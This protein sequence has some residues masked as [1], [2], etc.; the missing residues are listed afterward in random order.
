MNVQALSVTSV[1]RLPHK[2]VLKR[3][4]AGCLLLLLFSISAFADTVMTIWPSNAVPVRVD[5]GPDSAVELGVKFKSDVA[6]TIVGIRF[7]KGTANTGI[8]VGNLWSSAGARL[9]TATFSNETASGWQQVFFTTPVTI[10]S[11]TVYVA[12][13]YANN[14]HYSADTDYFSGKGVDNPPLHAL[15]NST[16]SGNGVYAYGT[17]SAFPNQ[18]WNAANYWV[19]V[20]FQAEQ[21]TLK[22][23]AVMPTNPTIWIG[24][25]LQFTATGTYSNGSTNNVSSQV[26]WTSSNTGVAT[27]NTNGL[28]TGVSTGTTTISVALAGVSNSTT[29]TVQA[30]PMLTSITVTP[31]NHNLERGR[32]LQ[33]TATGAYSNG[34]TNNVSS[35]VTWTSSNTGVATINTSGLATGV[36]TGTTT[37]SATL[38]NV[39]G[40]TMLTVQP[41][42]LSI[43]TTS[44]PPGVVNTAYSTTLAASGGTLPYTWSVVGGSLP[45]GLTLNTGSGTISGTPTV[46][47]TSNFTIQLRDAN[48]QTTNKVLSLTITST[49]IPAI[50][51]IWPSNAV[52]GN[53]DEGA[54]N[55]V[56]LGVKFKSDVAGTIVGIRFYKG[57]ANTGTHVGNLWSS[58]GAQLA[59]ATFSSETASGWQQ[60]FFTTPVTIASNTVYVASYHANNGHYSA[61]GNY[62][63]GKG[64]DNPPLHALT[65][66]TSSGNGVYVYGTSS[67]FP[68][69]TWNAANYWVDVLFQAEQLTLKSITVMPANPN[70]ERGRTLQ[71]TA[72]GAYS[73]GSTNNVSSQV[74]WTSSNT[75][76]ATINTSGLATGVSTGM[77][78][79]SAAL[80]S[81][82]NST[83]LTVQVPRTLTS[84]S[85]T[86]MNPP[87]WVGASLQFIATGTYSDGNTNNVSSQVT[88]TSSNTGVATI[89]TSGLATGVATGTTT[90]SA[91]LTNVVGSTML[92]V[93]PAPLSITTTSFSTGFV[94]TAYSTTLAASGGTLPYIWSVV[95]GSLPSGLTLNTGSGTISGTPTVVGTSN[96]T[97]QL[98]DA[99]SQTTNKVLSLTITSTSIPAI[100]TIWPSNAVP[101]NVDE[102]ADNPVELGVKFKSDV[103]GTIVGIRFYKA[104]ANTGTH[105]GNLWSSA[106]AQLATATFSSETA[107][108]WQQ[109]FFTTPVTIASNTVY[110]ASYHANNGHYSADGNYF[111]EKGVDNP[112][113]H[114]LTNSTSSGNGVYAYGTSSAFPNQTW[115]AANYWVDVLFQAGLRTLTSITVTP[116]SPS[117]WRGASLQFMATGTYSDGSTNNVSS[118]VTWTSSNMGVAT[119]N[120]NGLVTG[121][122][123]GAT[124]ISATLAGVSNST[125]LTVLPPPMLTSIT[126]TPANPNLERGRTLQFTAKGTYSDGSTQTLNQ[127]TWISSN[128]GVATINTNGLATGVSTGTT[129]ISATWTNVVGSTM[130]TV[131]SASLSITTISLPN[132]VVN[133]SY[134]ATLTAIGGTLPYTWSIASGSLPSGLTLNAANGVITGTPTNTGTVSFTA[135]VRDASN[136]AQTASNVLSLTIMPS[137][138]MVTIWPSNAMPARVDDGPSSPVELGVKFRSDVNGAIAGIR[139]YKAAAN[140]GTHVGNLWSITGTQLATATFANESTSGWQQVLFAAPV[141]ITSNTVYVA[142][143]H[144]NNGHYSEDDNYFQGK[145][146][147]N[148][149]LHALTNGVSGGNGVYVYGANSAFPNQTWLAANYWVD[150]LFQA[151]PITLRSIAVTPTN[152]TISTG[153]SQQFT[154]MGTFSDGSMQNLTSQA[155]WTSSNT[156]VA[157]IN[158]DGLAIGISADATT[159]SASLA[160]VV[161]STLLTVKS[162]SLSIT[163]IS[164]TN[165]VVNMAYTATLSASGGTSPY[166][167][168]IAGG[169]LPSGLTLNPAGGTITGTPT[170]TGTN[171]FTVQVRDTGNPAQTT[172]NLF[173]II[174][175]PALATIWPSTVVPSVVD[176][177]SDSAVELGV[178]FRSAVDGAITGIRFYKATA[179]TGTH[180]GN[181]WSITGTQLATATFSNETAAGW[182]QVLFATPVTIT[183]NTV[184]VASYH[185]NN[186]HYSADGNYF[187][188]K[189]VDNPPLY[190]LTNGVSGGNGVYA[191]GANSAFPNQT[192]NAANYWVDVLFRAGPPPN[193]TSIA[194]T[195]ANSMILMGDLKQ[196]TATGIYSDGSVQDV[197]SQATW[198]SSKPGVARIIT[199]GVVIGVSTGTTTISATLT[200]VVGSTTLTVQSAPLSI[201]TT[202][203]TNGMVNRPYAATLTANGGTFLP[204]T[205]SIAEGSLPVGLTLN[206]TNGTIT[207]TPTTTGTVYFTAHVSDAGNPIQTA[208][209]SLG[210]TIVPLPALVTIWPSTAVPGQM[211]SGPESP[212]EL[213]VKFRSDATGSIVGIRFYKSTANLGTHMGNLWTSNGILLATTTFTNETGWGWQQTYFATPVAIAS[214]TVYVASY[215]ANNG[216]YSADRDYF[217]GKGADNPPLH[218]LANGVSGGNGVYAYGASSTFPNQS[219][220]AANYWVDVIFRAGPLPT[221]TSIV[222]T[223]TN[224]SIIPGVSTQFMATGTFSDGSTQSLN[225]VTWTSLN[226][227]VATINASGLA[228]GISP[229]AT[230]ISAALTNVVGSTTLT[231][232]SAPLSIKTISLP[233]G[234]VNAAYSAKLTANGGTLPYTWSIT[235]GTLPSG[236]TLNTAAGTITGMPTTAGAVSFTAHVQDASNPLQTVTKS[237]SIK[238]TPVS[239]IL[240]VTNMAN[241]FSQYYA[242]ILLT[243][244]LNEFDLKD[245]SFVSNET[246]LAPYD[247]VILGQVA[248]QPSQV[249]IVSNWVN[250]GGNLIAMRPDKKLAGL[251]GLVD[252]GATMANRYLLVNTSTGPGAGIV[253]ETIQFHGT[254]DCYTVAS[255]THIVSLATL[256]SNVQTAT[257]HPAVTLRSVGSNGGQAAAFT[258]DL[259]RS[260]VY[261]RQGNPAWAGQARDGLLPVRS[262]DL[263]YGAATNDMQPDWIDLTNNKV[264][265]PQADEQQRLLANLILTMNSD[266]NLLP[267]FW[268][269]PHGYEAVVVMTEDDHG[270][271]VASR[272]DQ[273]NAFSPTNG[274]MADWETIRSTAYMFTNATLI[275]AQASNYNAVGFEIGLHLNTQCANYTRESLHVYFAEQLAQFS[276]IYPSV[277]LPKTLRAHCI[278]WS[279]YTTMPEVELLY[280]IRLD[281]NYYYYPSNWVADRPGFFTGSG[282]PMR[283]A[284]ATGDVIDVYQ[285]ATEMTDESGQS[286]PYTVDFL[287][288]RALGPEGYYGAFVA[289]AHTIDESVRESDAIIW[290]AKDREVPVISACQLLTW[291]DARNA[292]SLKSIR[293]NDNRQ[294]FSVNADTN[295]RG[296][297]AMAP[298]PDGYSVREIEGNGDSIGYYLR[299]V[300]GFQYAMFPVTNGDYEVSYGL[301]TNSPNI[302][303]IM[304]THGQS[305]V[306][307][308]TKVSVTFSE[309]MNASTI[310]TNTITLRDSSS[311]PVAATVSYNA[312]SFT[313]VLTPRDSLA[314]LANYTAVVK[315]NTSGV[316]DV[317]GNPRASDFVWAFTTVD[318]F[319]IWPA[320]AVPRRVD[321]GPSIALEVGVKFQSDVAGTITGIRF[322]KSVSNTGTH[323][324][325]L[326]S[327]A[328]ARLATATF[329]NE[330]ASGWQKALFTPPVAIASNT[331]YVASYHAD[332]GHYSEDDYYFQGQGVDNPP[333]HALANGVSSNGVYAYGS[334]STFPNQ[335]WSAA[336]YWV[337][338]VFL[339]E[340]RPF[341]PAQISNEVMAVGASS[342]ETETSAADENGEQ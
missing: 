40:S 63:S 222:V 142:S 247:V 76:V 302:M 27:I 66:S 186:G 260:I 50:V 172:S 193:L 151:E 7:Y 16:S 263:F 176:V 56:E 316:T 314:P 161:G 254:A 138:A 79:I 212:L 45:S 255:E 135:Y 67:A 185:V 253:G 104:V 219:F 53:V 231:V 42:P 330:T 323:V 136:P 258:Y 157:T 95:G 224:L 281:L 3:F 117:I 240:V 139:F 225:Q 9:A 310:N 242:E 54:D 20:L 308:N 65:N 175:M 156:G 192:H 55:P 283:F 181:L 121:V 332:N 144:A 304:P 143:Y 239:P 300:K 287:L 8:H 140:S 197:I 70:L 326:W 25:S 154:A 6:G 47:G 318:G 325:N 115:N 339:P 201:T 58:A 295:A 171:R 220:S 271:N 338:V 322:Y 207:G 290:S 35:Q 278:P 112:P 288:D 162:G 299:G 216:H 261:T 24:A 158:N 331:V 4:G 277:P 88:W 266:K 105:V 303:E 286:Y 77:T 203:L 236:L 336:N 81:V 155:A 59:T 103:A 133:M 320:T 124:I 11:N 309:A 297:L 267:R 14:G 100:V 342:L 272:F 210:I 23:I 80:A 200:N 62:F 262:D 195:P 268:Y 129:T 337:D 98:R 259:A 64:V 312:A 202:S 179:N 251:F 123:T 235:S 141:K 110:L 108:G 217:S 189:G 31:A 328:G 313:A 270:G 296:L 333:L 107:S 209:K 21:L 92:T 137:L 44:L 130:L 221:L 188:G 146:V 301:D 294:T 19:D 87:L 57:T 163:T 177:G 298:V 132:G 91:T 340:S 248:L 317:A 147:D 83:T 71:F 97:I 82:S 34:S 306:G 264:A 113:L 93:Q 120:T 279:D 307:L 280:G 335:S 334:S 229:G 128:T 265:I 223:P 196:F 51:T 213:G 90:I 190:A 215:H 252:T 214:D 125:T 291:L 284:T 118:Q 199:N 36:A 275:N 227:G 256:Y 341:P 114:A 168:S 94:N 69:Q 48:S 319:S 324:G 30:P 145:G 178:K 184:Y 187:S 1:N 167:W 285:A 327:S 5:D 269:F 37:I 32:T 13:Y 293:W 230:T 29:L 73:D 111:S 292:S 148:P 109:V 173:S 276:A 43:T 315:G 131:Q 170:S 12:S 15:T 126:V 96:F 218:A 84:I 106:G 116:M 153:A 234:V 46:V 17:S 22:S 18:T 329:V 152:S 273:H 182:Q 183:S 165:G 274:S 205:W 232:Q 241:P 61:D 228:I 164:L 85:V 52:P 238:I 75:G 246:L 257:L 150:V 282:M 160:G 289:N 33:F 78:T 194:V 49:S 39:V 244:G 41:A 127:V 249:S 122:S 89:N 204:Y 198:T 166:T 86:P 237:L 119:I 208:T 250:A 99:N 211:D 311:D 101:G 169:S 2:T 245:I 72:T 149:P 28:A 68:N 134:T 102:G 26:T 38:T 10:A 159:I 206:A 321:D 74:T 305:G 180:V 233:N 226:P 191:Y 243:E 60:V 174:I